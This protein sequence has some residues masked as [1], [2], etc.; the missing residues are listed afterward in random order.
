VANTANNYQPSLVLRQIISLSGSFPTTDN[1]VSFP[2]LAEM[3]LIAGTTATGLSA[4]QWPAM[5]NQVLGIQQNTALFS[6][7]GN[8]YGGNEVSTFA[9]PDLRARIDMGVVT[10]DPNSLTGS[11]VGQQ[12][13]PISLSQLAAHAHA[14]VALSITGIQHF[15]NGSAQVT[16]LG[17]LGSSCQ[18]DKSDDLSGWSTLGTVNFGTATQTIADPNPTHVTRRF[19][20]AHVP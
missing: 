3:R 12:A 15:A 19:Y 14:L 6:L 20:Y 18:V 1:G 5:Y 10:N 16:L 9:L 4:N 13:M 17:T 8:N 2:M 11:I 7:L